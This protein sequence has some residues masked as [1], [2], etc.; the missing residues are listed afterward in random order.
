M[1]AGSSTTVQGGNG[2]L[3]DVQQLPGSLRSSWAR[4]PRGQIRVHALSSD[5]TAIT[6]V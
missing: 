3:V 6:I 1:H 2:I 4:R 5:H